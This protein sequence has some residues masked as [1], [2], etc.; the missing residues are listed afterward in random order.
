MFVA[1]ARRLLAYPRRQRGFPTVDTE[2]GSARV[3]ETHHTVQS[4][5]PRLLHDMC[6][7]SRLSESVCARC[8]RG[9]NGGGGGDWEGAVRGGGGGG[10]PWQSKNGSHCNLPMHVKYTCASNRVL[11]GLDSVV[12]AFRIH[13]M[14]QSS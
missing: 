11:L 13:L 6:C 5:E 7:L 1:I 2:T 9:L 14:P 10:T 12:V 4:L 8:I 3:D